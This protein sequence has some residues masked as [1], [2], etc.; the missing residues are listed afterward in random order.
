ML[1]YNAISVLSE[2]ITSIYPI[3]LKLST[4]DVPFNT[5][6]R[7]SILFILSASF[8]NYSVLETVGITKLLTL[9]IVNIIHIL[10]SYYGFRALNPSLSSAIFYTYPFFN[11]IFSVLIFNEAIPLSKL[12]YVF[13]VSYFIYNI[14]R[15]NSQNI[16]NTFPQNLPVGIPMTIISALTESILYIILKSVNLGSNL[17]NPLFAI[18]S[19]SAIFYMI[20]YIGSLK[21]ND[22]NKIKEKS[23]EVLWL[24]ILNI[25]VGLVGQGLRFWSVTRVST[26]FYAVSS[27]S[28]I[29]STLVLGHYMGIEKTDTKKIMHFVGLIL[30]LIMM[31]FI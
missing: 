13:P 25:F 15:D 7:L 24:V 2:S 28:G 20:Y 14:Y 6:L 22:I 11:M 10:S 27:Y 3:I 26:L 21:K 29:F 1:I 23:N 12:F 9:S 30:S 16:S 17:W 8:A 18:Y 31:Q 5:F 4:L 19:L